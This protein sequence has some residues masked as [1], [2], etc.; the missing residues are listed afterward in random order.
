MVKYDCEVEKYV[1]HYGEGKKRAFDAAENAIEFG[2]QKMDEGLEVD[3]KQ[4]NVL[5]GWY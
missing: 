5:V 2:I 4:I 1:V 3:I